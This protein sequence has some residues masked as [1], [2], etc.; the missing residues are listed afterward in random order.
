[1]SEF[2]L[3]GVGVILVGA[4]IFVP[5]SLLLARLEKRRHVVHNDTGVVKA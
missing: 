5:F 4:V 2:L 3:M 1:M